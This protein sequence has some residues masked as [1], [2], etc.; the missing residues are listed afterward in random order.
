M[1]EIK[2]RS[3]AEVQDWLACLQAAGGTAFNRYETVEVADWFYAKLQRRIVVAD[4]DGWSRTP[5]LIKCKA[6]GKLSVGRESQWNTVDG[7]WVCGVCVDAVRVPITIGPP[8]EFRA[9]AG[10]LDIEA[11]DDEESKP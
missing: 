1:S 3:R 10:D 5:P 11:G 8:L 4:N 2:L 7:T 6:C 9:G